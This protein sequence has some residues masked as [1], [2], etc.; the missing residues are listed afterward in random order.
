M[1]ENAPPGV[2]GDEQDQSAT[3]GAPAEQEHESQ[4]SESGESGLTKAVDL[5]KELTLTDPACSGYFV[6]P[7]SMPSVI[8]VSAGPH[9]SL[10]VKVDGPLL[11]RWLAFWEDNLSQS[12]MQSEAWELRLGW[13]SLWV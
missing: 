8:N 3:S 5:S 11:E 2:Q 4:T 13:N 6:E 12:E 1:L 7:V 9:I 10:S